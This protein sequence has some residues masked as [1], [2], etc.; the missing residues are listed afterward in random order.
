MMWI[1]FGVNPNLLTFTVTVSSN[2]V[3]Q[4]S[5]SVDKHET[6]HNLTEMFGDAAALGWPKKQSAYRGKTKRAPGA[7]LKQFTDIST[8]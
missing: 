7:L 6:S 4:V 2:R 8:H 5:L 3:H 1:F